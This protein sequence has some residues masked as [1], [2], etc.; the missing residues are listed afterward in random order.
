MECIRAGAIR[1]QS[2]ATDDTGIEVETVVPQEVEI[3]I[4]IDTDRG[5]IPG[6]GTRGT[7]VLAPK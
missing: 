7:A 1:S 6:D 5:I 3:A 4:D 2:G